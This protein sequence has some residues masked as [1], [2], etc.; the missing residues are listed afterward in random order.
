MLSL[1]N[2]L[3]AKVAKQALVKRA[4]TLLALKKVL[5]MKAKVK[6]FLLLKK[7]ANGNAGKEYAFAVL[8]AVIYGLLNIIL[9][10]IW[11][12]VELVIMGS[13]FH[14]AVTAELTSIPATIINSVFMVVGIAV[15]YT[16]VKAAYHRAVKE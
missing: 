14:A 1:L 6:L 8:C 12:T 15:L 4:K 16:P 11:N 9:D 13:N 5:K 2:Y 10:F 7:R 3:T